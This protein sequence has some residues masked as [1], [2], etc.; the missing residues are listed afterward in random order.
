M[1][2]NVNGLMAMVISSLSREHWPRNTE[3]PEELKR[4]LKRF[5]KYRSRTLHHGRRGHVS[6]RDVQEFSLIV[7][8]V[9]VCVAH[10]VHQGVH[11]VNELSERIRIT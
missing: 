6:R 9:I 3:N 11:S 7:C 8:T 4:A 2:A 1:T 10:L 5:Y